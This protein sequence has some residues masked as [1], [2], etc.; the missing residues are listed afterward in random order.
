MEPFRP[1]RLR[2]TNGTAYEVRHPELVKV[3]RSQALIFFPKK[4]EPH[5]PFIRYEAVSLVHINQLIPLEEPS[6]S[7]AG[8]EEASA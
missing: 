5:A 8:S 3:G 7:V 1:F 2:L 4:D 6:S